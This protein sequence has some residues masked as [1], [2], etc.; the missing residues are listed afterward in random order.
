[1]T[2][3]PIVLRELRVRSRQKS[4]YW[5]RQA[6]AMTAIIIVTFMLMGTGV[7]ASPGRL[8][9]SVFRFMAWLAFLFCLIEGARNTADSLS[10]EK[11][12]GTLGLLFLTD[13]KGYD[14]V[15][16]KMMATSLNSIYVLVA[17]LPPMAIPLLVGGVTAGEFWRLVLVLLVTLTLSLAVG[18][19]VSALSRDSQRAWTAS[20]LLLALLALLA[21]PALLWPFFNTLTPTA[22][23]LGLTDVAY[24]A[25]PGTYWQSVL[26]TTLLSTGLFVFA[27]FALP[28]VWQERS[29]LVPGWLQGSLR[30]AQ[31]DSGA[32]VAQRMRLL[33]MN[34][35]RWAAERASSNAIYVW[36]FM[37]VVCLA[38]IVTMIVAPGSPSVAGGLA[39][40]GF[41]LYVVMGIWVAT[42]ACHLFPGARQSG[43]LELLLCTPLPVRDIVDGH[44]QAL[45]KLFTGPILLLI[46]TMLLL[47]ASHLYSRGST[48]SA[49]EPF[50]LFVAAGLGALLLVLDLHAVGRFGM[51]MGLK[52]RRA[53]L[54]VT[55][56]IA[57][58]LLL[59]LLAVPFCIFVFFFL[60]IGWI[61]K[62]LI[63]INYARDQIV[64]Q[65]RRAATEA[66]GLEPARQKPPRLPPVLP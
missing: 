22:A 27:S 52:S 11:R 8:G 25:N 63:F 59:P 6:G 12:A 54:A 32:R 61:V 33:A 29:L 7:I 16:G 37:I 53:G 28:R 26:G 47:V 31:A 4:T 35:A 50:L 39:I 65:F 10:E 30:P 56:T 20:Y 48:V 46:T 49:A 18:L 51:W 44:F 43:A 5:F 3:L 24:R 66:A 62:D 14:V 36:A 17:I 34:P 58:V 2:F 19:F 9:A 55:K 15:F 57:F 40:A 42:E 1:M 41:A 64:R 45:Q 38:A 23:L 13:L 21:G 60:P